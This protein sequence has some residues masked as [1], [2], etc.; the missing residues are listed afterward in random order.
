M[1]H[2]WR[3]AEL[4]A[5]HAN[6]VRKKTEALLELSA[7]SFNHPR[8]PDSAHF[9]PCFRRWRE[10]SERAILVESEIARIQGEA[11]SLTADARGNKECGLWR[12]VCPGIATS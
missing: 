5:A 11:S 1:D 8:L 2:A 10:F 7:T 6:L 9:N 12:A 4:H 3:L